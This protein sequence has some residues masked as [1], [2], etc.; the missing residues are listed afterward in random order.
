MR[1][2]H[3]SCEVHAEA[4]ETVHRQLSNTTSHGS[5]MCWTAIIFTRYSTAS[6]SSV[7]LFFTETAIVSSIRVT[8]SS[9]WSTMWHYVLYA[10]LFL[11]ALAR[12][13]Q[14]SAV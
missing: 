5:V 13:S 4:E 6:F 12:W 9:S 1:Q 7:F 2:A 8:T 3:V 14:R 11:S 10:R